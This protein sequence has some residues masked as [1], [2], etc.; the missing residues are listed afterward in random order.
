MKNKTFC[1]ILPLLLLTPA[2]AWTEPVAKEIYYTKKHD[3]TNQN[4]KVVKCGDTS[5][6][7]NNTVTTLD[8]T[9]NVGQYTAITIGTD[10]LQIISYFDNTNY[11]LKVVKCANPFCID[12]WSRR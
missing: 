7:A 4:L 9:G 1:L 12:K 2:M 5:C 3:Y 8:S 10:G 6:S 11:D